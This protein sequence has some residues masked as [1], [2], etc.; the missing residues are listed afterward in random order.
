MYEESLITSSREFHNFGG[1]VMRLRSSHVTVWCLGITG[2]NL[3]DWYLGSLRC[4]YN[5]NIVWMC[6][7]D[8]SCDD[9]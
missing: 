7:G 4:L 9:L 2:V 1:M 8:C 6:A 5:S 3:L